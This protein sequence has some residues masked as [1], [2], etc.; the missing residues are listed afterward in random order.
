MVWENDGRGDVRLADADLAA[1]RAEAAI[2]SAPVVDGVD[3]LAAEAARG[4]TRALEALMV[5]CRGS[6]MAD[7]LARLGRRDDAEDAVQEAMARACRSVSRFR[8]GARW[9]PWFARILRNVCTDAVHRQRVAANSPLGAA[10]TDRGAGPEQTVLERERRAGLTRAVAE[11]PEPLR[12]PLIMHYVL[13]RTRHEIAD[14]LG[15]PESTVVGRLAGALRRL[16]RK[17]AAL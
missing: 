5:G 15:L 7:A 6:A 4:N 11:L 2:P 13:G 17:G 1:M 12:T 14:A 16:R 9:A 10:L 3:R 8:P